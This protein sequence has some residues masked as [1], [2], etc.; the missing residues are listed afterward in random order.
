MRP[1]L[2][3]ELLAA[4]RAATRLRAAA[5]YRRAPY[6]PGF[7]PPTRRACRLR[8]HAARAP[9][10]A[11]ASGPAL[12]HR[13]ARRA[14][15]LPRARAFRRHHGLDLR[16]A[17]R[18]GAARGGAPRARLVLETDAPYLLPRTIQPKPPHRR[19]EPAYL[20][21]VLRATADCRGEDESAL[22]EI[23]TANACRFF[24]LT[25]APGPDGVTAEVV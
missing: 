13:R 12:L 2:L 25:L 14:R 8:V 3:P 23:T 19:N 15:G 20:P 5:R 11:D 17:S 16:R 24:G 6:A 7:P 18:P 1:R 22:A 9:A 4:R 10:V 21:D